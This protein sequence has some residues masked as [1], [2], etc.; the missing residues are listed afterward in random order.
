M[1]S[2]INYSAD[3]AATDEGKDQDQKSLVRH[4]GSTVI[5]RVSFYHSNPKLYSFHEG[6][7][8][9]CLHGTTLTF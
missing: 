8:E 9:Y 4:P 1:S 5:N 2:H 7:T 6:M 3:I